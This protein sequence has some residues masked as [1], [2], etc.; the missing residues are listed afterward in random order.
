MKIIKFLISLTDKFYANIYNAYIPGY[1]FGGGGEVVLIWMIGGLTTA[2]LPILGLAKV[3][4]PAM[5]V[6]NLLFILLITIL[7]NAVPILLGYY[8]YCRK[9][10][11][12]IKI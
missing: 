11:K 8:F 6:E 2:E 10:K 7:S 3:I 12:E 1:A 5:K 9:K 4:T